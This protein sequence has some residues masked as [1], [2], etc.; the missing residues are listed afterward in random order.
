MYAVVRFIPGQTFDRTAY[1]VC[2]LSLCTL[3][4]QRSVSRVVLLN[5]SLSSRKQ[6]ARW[7]HSVPKEH[8]EIKDRERHSQTTTRTA[9]GVDSYH[10]EA[11]VRWRPSR[12]LRDF[13]GRIR[14]G[15]GARRRQPPTSWMAAALRMISILP[16][17]L[18]RCRSSTHNV[19]YHKPYQA[20]VHSL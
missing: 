2:D 10:A 15:E 4:N 14:G 16:I 12:A 18:P 1:P 11:R 6:A 17:I 13:R 20:L 8:A 3:Y 9:K 7:L 19:V 5:Q